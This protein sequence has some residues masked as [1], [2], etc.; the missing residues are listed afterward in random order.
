M[1]TDNYSESDNSVH[2]LTGAYMA[3]ALESAEFDAYTA[4]LFQCD[5]CLAEIA[6]MELATE[7]LFFGEAAPVSDDLMAKVL[8]VPGR[9]GTTSVFEPTAL[10]TQ[11]VKPKS[12]RLRMFALAAAFSLIVGFG[13]VI[14]QSRTLSR[15]EQV[16]A[17]SDARS[18]DLAGE[19]FSVQL[20]ISESSSS[21]AFIDQEFSAID[22][23]QGYA[24]WRIPREGNPEFL[25]LIDLNRNRRTEQ[26][27]DA[28]ITDAAAF[29]VSIENLGTTPDA[30]S[31]EVVLV[32]ALG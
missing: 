19:N 7:R 9:P 6:D 29:A 25:G 17:M 30:P 13:L 28:I 3:G 1:S 26:A 22:P 10:T 5:P 2:S 24:L 16:A 21:V 32:G 23:D 11:S 8:A 18:L 14:N 20:V 15:A 12:A 4:H 31:D 27:F